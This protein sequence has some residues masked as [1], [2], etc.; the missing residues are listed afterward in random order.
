MILSGRRVNDN[1]GMFVSNKV[2]KMMVAQDK[3]IKNV[4]VL[5]LGF[6]FKENCPNVRNTRVIDIYKEL[7]SFS[8]AVDVMIHGQIR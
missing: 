6:A 4:K 7:K 3:A 2:I 8:I 1:M 5:M